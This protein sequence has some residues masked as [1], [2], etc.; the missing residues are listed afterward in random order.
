M[1]KNK[2]EFRIDKEKCKG[3]FL[4]VEFCPNAVLKPSTDVN[5]KGSRYV[6]L[7]H[8]ENCMFCGMCHAMCPDCGIEMV[9]V[10]EE[11]KK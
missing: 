6:K 11:K 3:C 1:A 9:V 4:C 8:P 10:T 5:A 7:D 2:T